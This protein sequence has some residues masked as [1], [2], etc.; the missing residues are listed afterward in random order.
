MQETRKESKSR[1]GSSQRRDSSE[2]GP[3]E[4]VPEAGGGLQRR[5]W[6][7]EAMIAELCMY[8]YIER[9]CLYVCANH[10]DVAT[11]GRCSPCQ[12]TRAKKQVQ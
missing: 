6:V 11:L 5:G 3:G 4:A 9:E 1:T 2:G 7:T 12:N 10:C 8:M